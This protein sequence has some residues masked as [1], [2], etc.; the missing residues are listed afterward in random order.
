LAPWKG[1][2]LGFS[3]F[4]AA[5][6][7][8]AKYLRTN[9]HPNAQVKMSRAVVGQGQVMIAIEGLS[10]DQPAVADASIEPKVDVRGFRI[11]G[12]TLVTETDARQLLAGL[13]GRPLSAKEIEQAAQLISNHLRSLGFPFAQ[14]YLPPQRLDAGIV[15]I[16]ILEGRLDPNAGKSGIVI[17]TAGH[18]ADPD[19]IQSLIAAGARPGEPL[20]IADLERAVLL[21]G[22]TPGVKNVDAEIEPGATTGTTQVRVKLAETS[23]IGLS[24]WSDNYGNRYTGEERVGIQVALNSLTGYGEQLAVQH[25]ASDDSENTRVSFSLP[26]GRQGFRLGLAHSEAKADFGLDMRTLDL[27]SDATVSTLSASYPLIR[28]AQQNVAL[29][30]ALERKHYITDLVWGRE[31]DRLIKS[32]TFSGSGDFID[33]AGGQNRWTVGL[34]AGNVDLSRDA[35]AQDRD[36]D[37]AK[38]AGDFAKINFQSIR[39][40]P[41]DGSKRLS[42]MLYLAGQYASKNLDS[43]EKFQLGGPQGVRAYP[44]SEGIGDHG[45]LANAEIRYKIPEKYLKSTHVFSFFDIGGIAQ[46][47]NPWSYPETTSAP[48]NYLL[49]G[50]GL[51]ANLSFGDTGSVKFMWAHKVGDNPNRS[52]DGLDSDGL[53]KSGRIWILGNIVF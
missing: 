26:L 1:R 8:V 38:T 12:S 49:K 7:A 19:R 3:E 27:N 40:A 17:E 41:I 15:E 20:R 47:R 13:S 24:L 52:S 16:A 11:S 6:H 43:A 39:V 10:A 45:W 9:G 23:P 21:V 50:A 31:N 37:T 5:I 14:A 25:V 44:V 46:Y 34:T 18:R 22:D 51:G 29:A 28:S 42:W 2:D 53:N 35:Q 32:G 30:L 36:A 4:E 33:L 48:N